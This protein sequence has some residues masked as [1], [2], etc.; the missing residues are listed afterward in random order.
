M[1]HFY[2]KHG[3]PHHTQVIKSGPNKGELR[4]TNIGDAKRLA[5]RKHKDHVILLPSA[6]EY[7]NMLAK[8]FLIDWKAEEVLKI[9]FDRP[10]IGRERCDG[11]VRHIMGKFKERQDRDVMGRGTELHNELESYF[12]SSNGDIVSK[13]HDFIEPVIEI[14]EAFDSPVAH[15]EKVVVNAAMGY[16]GTADIILES[17]AIIDFKTKD[18]K[19]RAEANPDFTHCMQ[20]AAYFVAHNGHD[21]FLPC[22]NIYFDRNVPDVTFVKEWTPKELAKGWE[23]FQACITLYRLV[24]GY[25]ARQ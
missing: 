25:D 24:N 6:S 18:F 8:S 1:S 16:A 3:K 22:R 4:D 21:D 12:T 11:W 7:I 19:G 5:N 17:G 23:A 10:P 14:V 20:C 9:A 15:A 13:D 2:D